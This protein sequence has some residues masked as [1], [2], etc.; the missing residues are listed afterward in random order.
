MGRPL[1]ERA[2]ELNE[3][4]RAGWETSSKGLKTWQWRW[5]ETKFQ[6]I[7]RRW[8]VPTLQCILPLRD[9]HTY[10]LHHL[11]DISSNIKFR[12]FNVECLILVFKL[13]RIA[14]WAMVHLFPFINASKMAVG[15][16]GRDSLLPR[17]PRSEV[18]KA[19]TVH[20]SSPQTAPH[21]AT[22]CKI[23]SLHPSHSE[24]SS[25]QTA[26]ALLRD[27]WSLGLIDI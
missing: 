10:D 3:T 14:T 16:L 13:A 17:R 9:F 2:C 5:K 11:H 27:L 15:P 22:Q 4:Q 7:F 26:A 20:N 23:S 24:C 18:K 6:S 8:N 12:L 1:T 25:T 19:R 21:F